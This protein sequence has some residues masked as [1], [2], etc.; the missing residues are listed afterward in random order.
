MKKSPSMAPPRKLR[1]RTESLRVLTADDLTRVHGGT[2]ET[3][4][5]DEKVK[6]S[7]R[8]TWCY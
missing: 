2:G 6:T 1:L 8:S 5:S 7:P 4:E 3:T